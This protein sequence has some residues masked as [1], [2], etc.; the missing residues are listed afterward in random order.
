MWTCTSCTK[1]LWRRDDPDGTRRLYIGRFK[2]D[3]PEGWEKHWVRF[4][5]LRPAKAVR[6]IIESGYPTNF[7]GQTVNQEE[8]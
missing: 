4:W 8:V 6:K 3:Y 5:A 1:T 2:C 7:E